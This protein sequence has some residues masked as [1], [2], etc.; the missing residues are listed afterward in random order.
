MT[1]LIRLL[2]LVMLLPVVVLM[3]GCDGTLPQL[4]A[5]SATKAPPT[6]KRIVGSDLPGAMGKTIADQDKI[7]SA[8]TGLCSV[9]VYD[10]KTCAEHGQA[11]EARRDELP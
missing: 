10:K 5:S 3:T 1:W 4:N 7:D 6:V 11:S 8:M 2:M 9:Q